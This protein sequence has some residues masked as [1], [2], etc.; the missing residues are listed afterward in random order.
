MFVYMY[1]CMYAHACN[2]MVTYSQ[3]DC[4]PHQ[5]SLAGMA[6]AATRR[7]QGCTKGHRMGTT[8]M[9]WADS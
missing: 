4:H 1:T 6:E 3:Q 2:I 9:E 7:Y 5:D 8:A